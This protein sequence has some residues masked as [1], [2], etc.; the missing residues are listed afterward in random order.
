MNDRQV[1]VLE[2]MRWTNFIVLCIEGNY[3]TKFRSDFLISHQ[4][5]DESTDVHDVLCYLWFHQYILSL[6]SQW[7]SEDYSA[8]VTIFCR[9]RIFVHLDFL[10]VFTSTIIQ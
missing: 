5:L 9:H 3:Y 7:L 1:F 4:K 6:K 10:L 8:K 2:E